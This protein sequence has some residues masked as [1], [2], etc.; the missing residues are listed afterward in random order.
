MKLNKINE[1]NN[2]IHETQK[3]IIP[4]MP[5]YKHTIK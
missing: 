2:T 3:K 1:V 4:Y 5:I